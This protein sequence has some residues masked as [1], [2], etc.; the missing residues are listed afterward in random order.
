MRANSALKQVVQKRVLKG[1]DAVIKPAGQ[2][3]LKTGQGPGK[4]HIPGL[5]G[6]ERAH[7]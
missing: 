7:P 5:P 6:S 4:T 1:H 2:R 3:Q